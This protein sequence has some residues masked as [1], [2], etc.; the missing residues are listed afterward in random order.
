MGAENNWTLP[1]ITTSFID[2]IFADEK[3]PEQNLIDH[4]SNTILPFGDS[5]LESAQISGG[6]SLSSFAKNRSKERIE[7]ILKYEGSRNYSPGDSVG[8]IPQN[9][10]EE[11]DELLRLLDLESKADALVRLRLIDGSKKKLPPYLPLDTTPRYLLTN[12]IDIRGILK[13]AFLRSLAEFT[14]DT[15]DRNF[16]LGLCSKEGSTKYN[17]IVLR[18]QF[19]LC[20]FLR[21]RPSC[22]PPLHLLLEHLPRLLPRAYTIASSPKRY[23]NQIRIVFTVVTTTSGKPGICTSWLKEKYESFADLS[24]QVANLK[25][26][27]DEKINDPICDQ[28]LLYFRK[29][30]DFRCPDPGIPSILIGPGSGIAPFVGF[31][32]HLACEGGCQKSEKNID[33]CL[34]FGC[35]YP[36]EDQIYKDDMEGFMSRGVLTKNRVCFSRDPEKSNNCKY[37]QDLLYEDRDEI[38]ELMKN[39]NCKIFVCGDASHMAKDVDATILTILREKSGI[40]NEEAVLELKELEKSKR[41]MKDVWR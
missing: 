34:Y 41:Y 5:Q 19:L 29:P 10:P 1:P 40:T 21:Q 3:P 6:K 37:V 35:R 8:I 25:L 11:V 33:R 7:L 18:Q 9:R 2:C 14:S 24:T 20:D 38:Y 30:N 27:S 13:K 12:V 31:L 36:N 23:P 26:S 28:V 17:E 15:A 16:I 4:L 39:R 22:K 32:E